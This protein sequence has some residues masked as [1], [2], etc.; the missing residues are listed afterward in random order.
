MICEYSCRLTSIKR[1]KPICF[2]FQ[3]LAF[4]DNNFNI[5]TLSF[6]IKIHFCH[7]THT[8]PT[9]L[10]WPN[11]PPSPWAHE[12]HASQQVSFLPVVP[13]VSRTVRLL[14]HNL[15]KEA[16]SK[17]HWNANTLKVFLRGWRSPGKR[18]Q[19]KVGESLSTSY[20]FAVDVPEHLSCNQEAYEF[21]PRL[22]TSHTLTFPGYPFTSGGMCF[23]PS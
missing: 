10:P 23:A 20:K 18:W 4:F 3:K 11:L 12:P 8:S 1:S 15:P 2:L 21:S 16:K 22:K 5:S 17:Y 19:K 13:G 9:Q 6:S 14:P 7:L